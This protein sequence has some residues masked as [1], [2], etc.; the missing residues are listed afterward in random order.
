MKFII[1]GAGAVGCLIG[2][3]LQRTGHQAVL[4][5]RGAHLEALQHDGLEL[6]RP[7]GV[8]R[9]PVTAIGDLS[10]TDIEETDC[11]VLTMKGRDTGPALEQLAAIAPANTTIVCAQNGVDNERSALRY[12]QRVYGMVVLMPVTLVRPGVVENPIAPSA[13]IL[14]V[15]CY[16]GGSD[17]FARQLAAD[18]DAA[19]FSSR[20]VDDIMRWKAAKLVQS[21]VTALDAFL[22]DS[23]A[24]Q[25]LAKEAEREARACLDAAGIA[26]ASVEEMTERRAG[27]MARALIEGVD[28]APRPSLMQSLDRGAGTVETPYFNGEIAMLGRLHGVA[29]PVNAALVRLSLRLAREK[30]A[31]HGLDIAELQ[32]LVSE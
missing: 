12:F 16:P 7:D 3:L 29:C 13:G 14:D 9:M 17:D 5:A 25:A 4:V 15:G 22:P 18:L 2:G 32:A 21:A 11:V 20:A 24:R 26:F 23:D 8:L 19:G 1:V 27:V 30:G 10:E 28:V 6:R 31:A